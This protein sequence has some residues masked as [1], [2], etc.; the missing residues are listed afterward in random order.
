MASGEW[1]N[2]Q[3]VPNPLTYINQDRWD[4]EVTMN[5]YNSDGMAMTMED[6]L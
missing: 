5:K 1:S 6:A 4:D 2:L 3:Y